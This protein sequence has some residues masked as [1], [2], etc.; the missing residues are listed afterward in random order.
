MENKMENLKKLEVWQECQNGQLEMAIIKQLFED[1]IIDYED[2]FDVIVNFFKKNNR[3]NGKNLVQILFNGEHIFEVKNVYRIHTVQF[4]TLK[5]VKE[6]G[7]Y[8][9]M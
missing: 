4:C 8:L 1:N 6:W 3:A 2:T 9:P 5:R 7:N